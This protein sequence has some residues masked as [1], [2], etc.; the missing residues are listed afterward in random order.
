[1][2]G[3]ILSPLWVTAIVYLGFPAAAAAIGA[4]TVI[5]TWFLASRYF[6]RTP[7]RWG[8]RRTAKRRAR[9]PLL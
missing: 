4:A 2:A 3:L 6:A 7:S 8:C 5:I 9:P 1:V